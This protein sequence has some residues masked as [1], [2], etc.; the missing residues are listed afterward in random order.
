MNSVP[1]DEELPLTK[2]LEELRTRMVIVII[3]ITI[4]TAVTFLFSGELLKL[5]WEQA[6]PVSMTIYS[7]MELIITK[8]TLS[9][10]CALFFGIPLL[11]YEAFRFVGKGLYKNEKL[12]FIK[13]VPLSFVLFLI[14]AA[15]AYFIAMPLIFKYTMFYSIDIATPQVSVIKTISAMTTLVL[16]FGLIFQFPLLLIFALKMD[17]LKVEYLKSKRKIVYGALLAFALFISPDPSAISELIVAATL[18]ILFEF[19]LLVARFF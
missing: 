7:P 18:V 16:S 17:I 13:I 9:L 8:L 4:V 11:I 5:I 10:M 1:G 12:F 14:G 3:P 19:S 6:V 15:L 2:H